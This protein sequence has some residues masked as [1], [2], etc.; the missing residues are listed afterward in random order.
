MVHT[1]LHHLLQWKHY[2]L[3]L[4]MALL[5]KKKS[6][7]HSIESIPFFSTIA[8]SVV[9]LFSVFLYLLVGELRQTTLALKA[10]TFQ[11]VDAVENGISSLPVQ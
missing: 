10:A 11:K 8:W 6:G 9:V 2:S 3:T 7:D 4:G 1:K 5:S